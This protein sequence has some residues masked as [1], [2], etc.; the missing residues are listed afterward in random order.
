MRWL[1][2]LNRRVSKK[3]GGEGKF[4]K[5]HSIIKVHGITVYL[6]T[7]FEVE[8]LFDF[9]PGSNMAYSVMTSGTTGKPKCVRVPHR[10]VMP[11][12]E[13]IR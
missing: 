10:C 4:R 13:H 9:N 7:L 12:I 5:L 11:N 1:F 8:N 2:T 3:L 6:W